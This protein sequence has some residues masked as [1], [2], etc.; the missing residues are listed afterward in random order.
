MAAFSTH[1]QQAL[2]SCPPWEI[3]PEQIHLNLITSQ[4][5]HIQILSYWGLRLQ[6][7]NLRIRE[8]HEHSV[9]I[10]CKYQVYRWLR[11]LW[12]S[13]S[14]LFIGLDVRAYL[15]CQETLQ[16]QVSPQ[17]PWESPSSLPCLLAVT[18]VKHSWRRHL[19]PTRWV[20]IGQ[21][22]TEHSHSFWVVTSGP[23]T[24][25]YPLKQKGKALENNCPWWKF[26][27]LPVCW[28]VGIGFLKQGS[29]LVMMREN[30]NKIGEAN[31]EHWNH[32][33]VEIKWLCNC[34]T[35]NSCYVI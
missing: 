7:M 8:R 4:R 2:G 14:L 15:G 5:I 12:V 30:T 10:T 31:L 29:L 24:Q 1:N 19:S 16:G 27:S 20:M 26:H 18:S 32:W 25:F 17:Q 11:M 13:T 35:C 9:Y 22:L 28:N 6:H 23:M 34:L 3:N 33:T 21:S